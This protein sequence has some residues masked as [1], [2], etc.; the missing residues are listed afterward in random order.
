MRLQLKN[1]SLAQLV[2]HLP[3]KQRVPGSSPGRVTSTK[4][5]YLKAAFFVLKT[6]HWRAFATRA[7]FNNTEARE[8]FARQ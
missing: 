3:F 6:Y 7:N 5:C 8:A 1:D 2:E 4:S